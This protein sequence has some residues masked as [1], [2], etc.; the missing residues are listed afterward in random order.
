MFGTPKYRSVSEAIA[1]MQQFANRQGSGGVALSPAQQ[2][3]QAWD[4]AKRTNLERY[5]EILKGYQGRE[6]D[7]MGLIGGIGAQRGADIRQDWG[8]Q[9]AQGMQGLVS[10]GLTGTTIKPTM[11]MG[12]QRGMQGDLNRLAENMAQMKGQYLS[13]LRG[14]T[15]QF[16]ERRTDEYPNMPQD[17]ALIGGGGGGG[18][19][20]RSAR[21]MR[22]GG[23]WAAR[24]PASRPAGGPAY[25]SIEYWNRM[26]ALQRARQQAQSNLSRRGSYIAP[27]SSR[28]YAAGSQGEAGYNTW[29]QRYFSP[30]A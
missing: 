15:L 4:E 27:M 7:V 26:M 28:A 17:L 20:R 18:Y 21:N 10:S 9:Q 5:A 22:I 29:G 3:Q 6:G 19:T 23:D 1:A 13:N 14:D 12:Y 8:N 11:Q 16:M 30:W 24:S 2:L 25:G